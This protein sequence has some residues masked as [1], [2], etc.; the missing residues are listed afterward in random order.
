MQTNG[1]VTFSKLTQIIE[2]P[3]L[4][5]IQLKSYHDFLQDHIRPEQ[6]KERGLQAVFTNI[7]PIIDSRE[8]FCLEFV[9]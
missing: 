9:E 5:D 2:L 7:F 1:R 4:L 8:N 3:D 6:R